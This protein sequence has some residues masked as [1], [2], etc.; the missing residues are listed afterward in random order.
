[1][2]EEKIMF[3]A[4]M[5]QDEKVVMESIFELIE[6]EDRQFMEDIEKLITHYLGCCC[7]ERSPE[8]TVSEIISN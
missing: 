4:E 5:T 6:G 2:K 8:E 1:M 7:Q 3:A